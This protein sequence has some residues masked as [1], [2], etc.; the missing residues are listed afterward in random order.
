MRPIFTGPYP[1]RFSRARCCTAAVDLAASARGT[2]TGVTVAATNT[3]TDAVAAASAALATTPPPL[4]ALQQM[5]KLTVCR[6]RRR[7][8]AGAFSS[9]PFSSVAPAPFSLPILAV[10]VTAAQALN[11]LALRSAPTSTQMAKLPVRV[12]TQLV[13]WRRSRSCCAIVSVSPAGDADSSNGRACMWAAHAGRGEVMARLC[14][15]IGWVAAGKRFEAR[16]SEQPATTPL[17]LLSSVSSPSTCPPAPSVIA[18]SAAASADSSSSGAAAAASVGSL[19]TARRCYSSA[20][21]ADGPRP[22]TAAGSAMSPSEGAAAQAAAGSTA[23][24][25]GCR[26][27]REGGSTESSD[28]SR[29]EVTEEQRTK[30]E[31]E[32]IVAPS[33]AEIY[34][35][36]RI[37]QLVQDDGRVVHEW[38]TAHVKQA[39]RTLAKQ[40]HPDVA[41]G[42]DELMEQVNT[43]YHLLMDLP[44]AL[45]ESYRMWLKAGGEAELQ[46]CAQERQELLRSRWASHDVEQLMMVGW[47]STLSGFAVYAMWRALYD[48]SPATSVVGDTASDGDG[49]AADCS[50]VRRGT[51][52]AE[53][54]P[55]GTRLTLPRAGATVLTAAGI[56]YGVVSIGGSVLW[57]PP[58]LSCQLLQLVRMAVS[59]YALAVALALAACMNTIMLQRILQRMLTGGG[60]KC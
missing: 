39:Y 38:T 25:M 35:A 48:S 49:A 13:Q 19:H 33:F 45:A 27:V 44:A 40:L 37:L 57:M 56:Q 22:A 4:R 42:D 8:G 21:H 18:S 47:C 52:A 1:A 41:G 43:S 9:A 32:T 30:E 7:R 60:G 29:E 23:S 26:E 17:T 59:R 31:G 34:T 53:V 12:L 5:R 55:A 46:M 2:A 20:A 16:S 54:L 28:N 58:R 10:R 24:T 36:F 15:S 51:S 6:G 11:S 14:S 3:T 50:K